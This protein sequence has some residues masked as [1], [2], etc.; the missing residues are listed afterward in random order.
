MARDHARDPASEASDLESAYARAIA[1]EE[2]GVERSDPEPSPMSR[3]SVPDS[4]GETEDE[5]LSDVYRQH[6]HQQSME[7]G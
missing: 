3:P 6:S 5:P 4:A 1:R 2:A 7:G